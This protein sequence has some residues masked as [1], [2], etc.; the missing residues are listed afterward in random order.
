MY[1]GRIWLFLG[2]GL[3]ALPVSV[4]VTLLQ[5]GLL[6]G[7]SFLGIPTEGEGGGIAVYVAVVV[8]TALSLAVL[9]LVQAATAR[10]LV[11]IDQGRQVSVR[12][13]YRLALESLRPLL[14]AVLRRGV[15]RLVAR[16]HDRPR[17]DRDLARSPVGAGCAGRRA[18]NAA[19]ALAALSRSGS[20]V[21]LGWFKVGS[22]VVVGA[23]MALLAG[24]LL[25]SL[26]ILLTTAPLVVL[27]IVSGIVYA[28]VLPF[29][30]LATVY[31]YFDMRVRDE[32]AE[33]AASDTLPAEISV[34]I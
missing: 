16:H 18:R 24:P 2:L 9:G 13:A 14:G 1:T 11:E 3:V 10:V 30:A 5:A 25:G 8:G 7:S 17:A 4:I 27:N 12:R 22:L 21:R 32:L 15:R 33:E 19:S 6:R 26:L 34:S 31:V 23:A 20:L 28:V 29:V